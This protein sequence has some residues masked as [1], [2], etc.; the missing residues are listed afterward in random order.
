[1]SCLPNP[2]YRLPHGDWT[3][4]NCTSHRPALETKRAKA[5]WEAGTSSNPGVYG[6]RPHD[7]V[8]DIDLLPPGTPMFSSNPPP[9]L[10]QDHPLS[11]NV[12]VSITS[13]RGRVLRRPVKYNPIFLSL[14]LFHNIFTTT[15]TTT[16][17]AP[18]NLKEALES[19]EAGD[20]M[21]ATVSEVSSLLEKGTF[22]V[23]DKGTKSCVKAKWVFK[24]KVDAFGNFVKYKARLVAKG[25]LQKFGVD[26]FDVFSPVTK[27]STLRTLLAYV[28]AHDLELRH[29]DVCTA[30]LNGELDEEVYIEVPEGLKD[31]YPGKCLRLKKA[32]YGLKQAPRVWWLNLSSTLSRFGFKPTYADQCL[33]TK[34]GKKGIVFC[35]VYVDDILFAGHAEDVEDAVDIILS[36]YEATDEGE[37]KSFLGMAITR[38]RKLRTLKL[39]QSAYVEDIAKRFNF[40]VEHSNKRATVPITHVPESDVSPPL[41]SNKAGDYASLVGSLLYLANCTRPDISFAVSTLARYFAAPTEGTFK[42]AKQLLRYCIATKEH[43]LTFGPGTD[44]NPLNLVGYSDSDYGNARFTLEDQPVSRR[45]VSG[46]VFLINGTPVAWQSKKQA[47]MARSTDD[48]EYI[49][50]ATSASTGL[51][52]R[53]LLGEM[54]GIFEPLT[55]YGDNTAALKH[56]ECP[57][58]INKSKHIDIAYQFI[59]DRALRNDLKFKYVPSSEN[60]ADIFTKALGAAL[61]LKLKGMLGSTS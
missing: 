31:L 12:P 46:F 11:S 3:C 52:L 33:F 32:I 29:V 37:A 36:N 59:L 60:V 13:K 39:S 21:E 56:I 17:A 18:I 58:S 42:L 6:L 45:S 27:L 49:G 40:D 50:L 35:L 15:A 22:E 5:T 1:M 23:V 16:P 25:F 38:D 8:P 43:G 41:D 14:A 20:W 7:L 30:F 28:A 48:A 4:P 10:V 51:W 24:R 61:F 9:E 47:V 55:I 57:G 44:S 26:F 54:N 53:K 34:M 19:P 2:L